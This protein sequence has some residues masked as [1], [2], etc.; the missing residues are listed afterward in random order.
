[1]H[2]VQSFR[3]ADCDSNHYVAVAKVRERLA[4]N[5]QISHSLHTERFSLKKLNEVESKEQFCIEISN[6]FAALDDLDAELDIN[7]AW[8]MIRENIKIS[9]KESLGYLEL[10][11]HKPGFDEGMLKFIRSKE[12][13]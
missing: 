1:M 6:R 8:E 2:D 7:S 4:V 9:A 13:S 11:K 5:K 3:A 10:K 12:T